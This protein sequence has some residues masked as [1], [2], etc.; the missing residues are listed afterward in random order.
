MD[1]QLRG[2][3]ATL[4]ETPEEKLAQRRRV[5]AHL[6]AMAVREEM[7]AAEFRRNADRLDPDRPDDNGSGDWKGGPIG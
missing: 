1:A 3:G 4:N 6:R 7:L 2:P 5:V